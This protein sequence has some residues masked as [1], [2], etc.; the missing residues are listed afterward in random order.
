LA[1]AV[2]CPEWPQPWT[3]DVWSCSRASFEQVGRDYYI[4]C[5]WRRADSGHARRDLRSDATLSKNTIAVNVDHFSMDSLNDM[6]QQNSVM[7]M[8]QG[9]SAATEAEILHVTC[10]LLSAISRKDWT[11]YS[12]L[13]HPALTCFEPQATGHL[14]RSLLAAV[15]SGYWSRSFRLRH[16]P[17]WL[18]EHAVMHRDRHHTDTALSR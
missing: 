5:L 16:P 6:Q 3:R 4:P 10:E 17:R 2:A 11:T 14:V 7:Q 18:S 8:V 1:P 15:I 9:N 13:C 12:R